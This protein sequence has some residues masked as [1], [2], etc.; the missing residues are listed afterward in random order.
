MLIGEYTHSFD[1]KNRISLPA[2]FRSEMGKS[3]VMSRGLDTCI[4]LYSAKAWQALSGRLSGGGQE[5]SFVAPAS[6][7]FS[8]YLFGG[9]SDVDVDSAGRI[10]IPEFLRK[11]AKI[12]GNAVFVGVH[13]RVE[14][15]SEKAW[16]SYKE[17]LEGQGEA[18]A[19]KLGEAGFI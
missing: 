15:W 11:F 10:L 7:G 4:F 19:E 17:R 6:R 2:K 12:E 3:V 16:I 9:A 13:E 14:I 18:L 1:D 5:L 8:R